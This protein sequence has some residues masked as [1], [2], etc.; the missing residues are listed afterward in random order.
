MVGIQTQV[1]LAPTT[2]SYHWYLPFPDKNSWP[3]AGEGLWPGPRSAPYFI[4]ITAF[5]SPHVLGRPGGSM[6]VLS[7]CGMIYMEPHQLGWKPL[8]DSYMDTLP[9]SLTEEHKELVRPLG[10][11]RPSLAP[12]SSSQ[13]PSRRIFTIIIP[14]G[15]KEQGIT[16]LCPVIL[17]PG[18]YVSHFLLHAVRRLISPFSSTLSITLCP[19][20]FWCLRYVLYKGRNVTLPIAPPAE[21]SLEVALEVDGVRKSCVPLCTATPHASNPDSIPPYSRELEQVWNALI[22][23]VPIPFFPY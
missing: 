7:R 14:G 13:R 20:E 15:K 8:K 4:M 21:M 3:G 11:F 5:T 17:F 2:H 22:A 12:Y 10:L 16:H 18:Y 19:W 1:S 9:S 6:Y 23:A